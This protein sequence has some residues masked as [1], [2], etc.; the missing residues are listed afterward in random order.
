MPT[1]LL[2]IALT[3]LLQNLPHAIQVGDLAAHLANLIRVKRNLAGLSAGIIYVQDPL[4]MAFATGA[5]CARDP[6]RVKGMPFEQGTAEQV[7]KGWE[8]GH[9]LTGLLLIQLVSHLYR[10]YT[11][12]PRSSIH[13]LQ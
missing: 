7:V 4:A 3:D 8:L 11:Y 10:C 2:L 6:G 1:Q 13:F 9:Q 12:S 5:G